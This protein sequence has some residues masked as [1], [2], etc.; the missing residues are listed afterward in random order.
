LRT[1]ARCMTQCTRTPRLPSASISLSLFMVK[2]R[3]RCPV[4]PISRGVGAL[5]LCGADA[6]PAFA[7]GGD[8]E[9]K[10]SLTHGGFRVLVVSSDFFLFSTV[11]F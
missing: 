5:Q 6:R 3:K 4:S 11:I 2:S 9:V 1:I 8:D 7:A 10:W